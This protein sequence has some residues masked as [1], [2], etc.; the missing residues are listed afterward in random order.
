MSEEKTEK[1]ESKH[2]KPDWVK[3][4]PAE[5]ESLVLELAKKGE[6]P[7]KIGLILRDQ[8]GI[9]KAKLLGKKVS[10]ILREHKII[11]YPE[12]ENVS[13]K[14][15]NLKRHETT[16]K[17]DKQAKRSLGKQLWALNKLNSFVAAQ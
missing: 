2:V 3:M 15:E 7:A 8:H 11:K 10:Q 4:K 16:H 1:A 14:I 5:I 12:Q 13:A 9:P 17:H 6:S